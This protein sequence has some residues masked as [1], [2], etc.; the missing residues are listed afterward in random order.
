VVR[1]AIEA[2]LGSHRKEENCLSLA[3]RLGIL[4]AAKDLPKDLSTNKKYFSGFGE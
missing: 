4:G 3:K 1:E 2:F